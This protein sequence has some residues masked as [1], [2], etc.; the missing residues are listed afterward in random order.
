MLT[1]QNN[2]RLAFEAGYPRN[3]RCAGVERG[4][5]SEWNEIL[6]RYPRSPSMGHAI[7]RDSGVRRRRDGAGQSP[8]AGSTPATFP[9]RTLLPDA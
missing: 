1:P 5:K 7:E 8:V 9:V 2:R 3:D 6:A 4:T